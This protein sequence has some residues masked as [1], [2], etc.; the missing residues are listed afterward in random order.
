MIIK[1]FPETET[2]SPLRVIL[3]SLYLEPAYDMFDEII[4]EPNSLILIVVMNRPRDFEIARLLGW[5]RIP[6]RSAPK[7]VS[8][9]YLGFY[10]TKAFKNDKWKIQYISPVRGHELT[11]RRELLKDELNHPNAHQEYYKIQLGPI[12]KLPDPI[13]AESWR[14]ITFLYTT[15]GHMTNAKTI[16]DLVLSSEE[17]PVIWKALRERTNQTQVYQEDD[18]EVSDDTLLRLIGFMEQTGNK[19]EN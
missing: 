7:I 4:P 1:S 17:R 12:Y 3:S 2:K 6:L 10:F 8:V 5:Y 18:F 15:G 11:S 19:E 14:R 16:N 9:D 13:L